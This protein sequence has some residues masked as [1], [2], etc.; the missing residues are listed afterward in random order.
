VH[1]SRIIA[2]V[3]SWFLACAS[4]SSGQGR[5]V[6]LGCGADRVIV[7]LEGEMGAWFD[8]M[9]VECVSVKDDG[10]WIGDVQAGSHAG[11]YGGIGSRPFTLTCPA[12]FAVNRMAG[13]RGDYVNTIRITC[14]PITT[15]GHLGG[16]P[17]DEI[18]G[19]DQAGKV[20]FGPVGG[21][22]VGDAPFNEI[23]VSAVIYIDYILRV[24]CAY[25]VPYSLKSFTLA[26]Q[27][28]IGGG[29]ISATF[30]LNK[31]PEVIGGAPITITS[32]VPSVI[33]SRT[34]TVSDGTSQTFSLPT[35]SV[36]SSTAV[37]LSARFGAKTL[38]IPVT[39]IPPLV[40]PSR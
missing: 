9:R 11:G 35:H 20:A 12:N 1:H 16:T 30:T 22:V 4:V 15:A 23:V 17:Q 7:G 39:V 27:I 19:A 8:G 31:P 24:D 2:L 28:I 10:S 33:A 18:M 38:S 5:E 29:T 32:S 6:T 21:C 26:S 25:P 37:Q 14:T 40:R 36:S 34:V 13:I 3:A